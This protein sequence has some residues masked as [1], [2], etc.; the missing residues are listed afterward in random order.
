MGLLSLLSLV[1]SLHLIEAQIDPYNRNTPNNEPLNSNELSSNNYNPVQNPGYNT[2]YNNN[3]NNN[4]DP[5][6]NYNANNV[7]YSPGNTYFN[8]NFGG[9]QGSYGNVEELKC[10]EYWI[11]FQN[12]CYRFIKSPLKPYNEARRICQVSFN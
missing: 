7:N 5:N 8:Q 9:Y 12:S 10:P 1:V 3:N 6:R 11:Q 2:N 4:L